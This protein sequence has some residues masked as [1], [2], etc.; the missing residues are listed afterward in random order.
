[1]TQ[2]SLPTGT[3]NCGECREVSTKSLWPVERGQKLVCIDC[4]SILL[5]RPLKMRGSVPHYLDREGNFLGPVF[6]TGNDQT[7]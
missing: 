1:M 5:D 6:E 2:S 4:L 3:T 7:W